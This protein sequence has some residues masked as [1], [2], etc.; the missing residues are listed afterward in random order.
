MMITSRP[1]CCEG[2]NET[3]VA[4]APTFGMMNK[5]WLCTSPQWLISLAS[6]LCACV[7]KPPPVSLHPHSMATVPCL[8]HSAGFYLNPPPP[9]PSA[10]FVSSQ[11]VLVPAYLKWMVLPWRGFAACY[12]HCKY[13]STVPEGYTICTCSFVFE[14]ESNPPTLLSPLLSSP[15]RLH[16]VTSVLFLLS[17]LKQVCWSSVYIACSLCPHDTPTPLYPLDCPCW[18]SIVQEVGTIGVSLYVPVEHLWLVSF[19]NKHFLVEESDQLS[20]ILLTLCLLMFLFCTCEVP[21]VRTARCNIN[22][23]VCFHT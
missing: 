21:Y 5:S 18:V 19:V 15:P 17:G 13:W 6:A 4:L 23:R 14:Y 2:L 9:H 7:C 22:K 11:Q 3:F 1:G 10:G 20:F 8:S 12:D 16:H